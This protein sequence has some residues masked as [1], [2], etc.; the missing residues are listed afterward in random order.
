MG[1]AGVGSRGNV[2]RRRRVRGASCRKCRAR[3]V[4]SERPDLT[5]ERPSEG[6][7][8]SPAVGRGTATSPCAGR[9]GQPGLLAQGCG[10]PRAKEPLGTGVFT[11]ARKC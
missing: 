8:A 5:A 6:G 9:A 3:P 2:G 11:D 7:S 4:T 1:W 10:R